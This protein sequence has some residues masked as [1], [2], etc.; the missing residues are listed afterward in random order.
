MS[1]LAVVGRPIEDCELAALCQKVRNLQLPKRFG[2]G[3]FGSG[4]LG[5]RSREG[6]LGLHFDPNI[7]KEVFREFG[8]DDFDPGLA[9]ARTGELRAIA[10]FAVV[11]A[12]PSLRGVCRVHLRLL[13][14]IVSQRG[15]VL[16]AHCGIVW[17]S[18][19][20]L[21]ACGVSINNVLLQI[22]NKQCS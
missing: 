3:E 15:S 6:P 13:L 10:H 17:P 1:L 22:G 18:Q 7:L 19:I 2:V 8:A 5:L 20:R 14:S 11:A 16:L 4:L 9:G 21:A 12:G